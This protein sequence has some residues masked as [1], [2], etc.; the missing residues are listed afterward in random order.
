MVTLANIT[1]LD[2]PLGF[3]YSAPFRS[4]L[5]TSQTWSSMSGQALIASAGLASQASTCYA[6]LCEKTRSIV[7]RTPTIAAL[8]TDLVAAT[9]G[10]GG[11]YG[12]TYSDGSNLDNECI[13]ANFAGIPSGAPLTITRDLPRNRREF[14]PASN[15]WAGGCSRY[16]WSAFKPVLGSWRCASLSPA[17]MILQL[18]DGST[19]SIPSNGAS[20]LDMIAWFDYPDCTLLPFQNGWR[21]LVNR[22]SQQRY[23]DFSTAQGFVQSDVFLGGDAVAN[24]AFQ[25]VPVTKGVVNAAGSS[26]WIVHLAN[27]PSIFPGQQLRVIFISKIS[28]TWRDIRMNGLDAIANARIAASITESFRLIQSEFDG[29]FYGKGNNSNVTADQILISPAGTRFLGD[30]PHATLPDFHDYDLPYAMEIR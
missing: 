18:S 7:M 23:V 19:I 15:D 22:T 28:N 17:S 1:P 9:L 10:A 5:G 27:T 25:T 2:V 26:G 21:L 24:T 16:G 4:V 11:T 29:L 20:S 30:P 6:V 3:A 14:I 8:T 13:W 12:I